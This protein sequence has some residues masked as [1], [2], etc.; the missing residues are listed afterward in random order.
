MTS[1]LDTC[2]VGDEVVMDGCGPSGIRMR[3]FRRDG[4]RFICFTTR[5]SVIPFAHVD[6]TDATFLHG[7]VFRVIAGGRLEYVSD[8]E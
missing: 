7:G 5:N 2:N 3:K 4:G 1:L 8:Q 6:I